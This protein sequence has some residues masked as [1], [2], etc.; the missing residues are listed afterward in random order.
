M[1]SDPVAA[2]NAAAATVANASPQLI[3]D[4][5][6]IALWHEAVSAAAG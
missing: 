1:N 2:A 3:Q 4:E 6:T 5:V